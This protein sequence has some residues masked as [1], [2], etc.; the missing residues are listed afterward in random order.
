MVRACMP[1]VAA[2]R[3]PDV[4]LTTEGVSAALS[5]AVSADVRDKL[6]SRLG[7]ALTA[8][9]TDI[10]SYAYRVIPMREG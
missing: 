7:P 4:L 8:C 3:L 5:E 1:H 2:G 6:L 10:N 9:Q